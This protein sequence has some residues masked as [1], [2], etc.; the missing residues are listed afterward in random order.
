MKLNPLTWFRNEAETYSIGD[1]AVLRAFYGALSVLTGAGVRINQ[2][3]ALRCVAVLACLI[4][5]AETFAALP[6]DVFRRD[7]KR[8]LDAKDHP[9][10]RL[11]A[12]GPNELMH[13]GEFWRWKQLTEDRKGNAY[14]RIRWRGYQPLELWPMVNETPPRLVVDKETGTAVYHYLGDDFTAADAYPLR[15]VLHFKGPVLKTPYEGR[16]L[17]DLASETIGTTL[18]SEQFFGRLLGNGTHFPGYLETEKD[19]TPADLKAIRESLEG[20]SGL[21]E[22]GKLRIFDRGLK[23]QQNP[24]TMKDAQLTEQMRWQ[25]QQIC[26]VFRVQLAL[27]QDLTNG[28]YTNS[29]QQDLW[30]AKH[31]MTPICVNTEHTIRHRL[32]AREPE[33]F[34][35]HNLD[36]LLRGDYKTRTEGDATLVRAGIIHRNEA[37]GHYDLNPEPGLDVFTV[38]QNLGTLG[39][40]GTITGPTQGPRAGEDPAAGAQA[41]AVP[42]RAAAALAPLIADAREACRRRARTDE[43]RGR[44]RSETIAFCL[45]K[46]EPL[47]QAHEIAGLPFDAEAFMGEA[48]AGDSAATLAQEDQEDA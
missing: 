12:V 27:V 20:I 38:E 42:L 9:A 44:S 17:I 1:D 7:G 3:N 48:L 13:A 45:A 39:E 23:Y 30:L 29:E 40:D 25:L 16:S 15:D 11:L 26:S 34:S 33:M 22:A 43:K 6:V 4:V 32:F 19:L 18:A 36:G 14:V 37:R 2:D 5:R 28:T 47:Q 8:Q 21:S 41:R 31:T 35:K 46:L 24:M 10:Y